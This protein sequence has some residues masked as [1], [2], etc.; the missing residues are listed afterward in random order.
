MA[1]A[2]GR[3]WGM[4]LPQPWNSVSFPC[5]FTVLVSLLFFFTSI[6]SAQGQR[7]ATQAVQLVANPSSLNFGNIQV[8]STASLTGTLTNVGKDNLTIYNGL[9]SGTSFSMSG[10]TLPLTLTPGQ[11]YTLTISFSPTGSGSVSGTASFGSKSW[12]KQIDVALSGSGTAPGQLT[13]SPGTTNFGNV[14]VGTSA[15]LSGTLTA[16]GEPVTISSVNS[17]NAQFVLNGLALPFTLSAGQSASFTLTFT[18]QSAGSVTGTLSFANTAPGSPVVEALTGSGVSTQHS[19]SLTWTPS[20]SVVVG[21]NVY[22]SLVSGGPYT[23]INGTLDSATAYTDSSVSS[24]T[25]YY[26]VTTAVDS[27]GTESAYSNEVKAAIP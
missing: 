8:G 6:V 2:V 10:I 1:F 12:R 3:M 21:Y 20:T 24:S 9:I 7:T 5:T 15:Q 18:P 17:S 13:V 4:R 22:R 25:T 23:Q 11:S 19:V 14:N 27:T 16:T 26:Y